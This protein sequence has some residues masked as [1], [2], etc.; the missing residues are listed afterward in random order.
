M[1]PGKL[2]SKGCGCSIDLVNHPDSLIE[3]Y[4]NSLRVGVMNLVSIVLPENPPFIPF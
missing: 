1:C 3:G 4:P 2:L